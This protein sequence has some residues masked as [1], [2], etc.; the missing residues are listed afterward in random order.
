MRGKLVVGNWKMNGGL[1]TNAALLR[2][3]AAGWQPASG[4]EAAVC[5]P[6][7]YLPQARDVLMG[8]PWRWGAQDLSE[9]GSGICDRSRPF[10][11]APVR[12]R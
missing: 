8:T 11:T 5:V 6:F 9:H 7:P 1:A 10:V 4:R 12:R 3:L 2:A